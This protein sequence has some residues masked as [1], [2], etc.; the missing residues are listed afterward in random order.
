MSSPPSWRAD[1][2]ESRTTPGPVA[3]QQA[4]AGLP[5]PIDGVTGVVDDADLV[6]DDARYGRRLGFTGKLCIHPRQLHPA[7]T[8]FRPTEAE[9]HW[10]RRILS[11]D[12]NTSGV[13]VID[14]AM[15]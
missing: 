11:A 4:A 12:T 10:A 13:A 1:R 7:A 15:V 6:T 5:G 2:A 8:A 9:R 3:A 14:G